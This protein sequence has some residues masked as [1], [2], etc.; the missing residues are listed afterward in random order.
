MRV[1]IYAYEST[2]GGLH[3]IYDICVAG[4]DSAN[5][6]DD[7]G[8]TMAYEVIDSYSYLF[9]TEDYADDDGDDDVEV[10]YPEWTWARIMSKW[11]NIST[12]QLDAEAAEIGF[13][14]FV[15][16]YCTMDDETFDELI[17]TLKKT[18]FM[19]EVGYTNIGLYTVSTGLTREGEYETMICITADKTAIPAIYPNRAAAELG[20]KFWCIAA[21]ASPTKVWDV[22]EKKY[23]AL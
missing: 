7:I 3:G 14:A 5:E 21:A 2:Y 9:T 17:D 10:T 4:V 22:L 6:A 20:H 18:V 13:E 11:N 12:E 23:V 8:E 15:K 1:V 19:D 16:K